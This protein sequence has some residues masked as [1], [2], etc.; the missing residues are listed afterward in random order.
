MTGSKYSYAATQL[1]SQG[2]LNP[3]AHMFLQDDF[4]QAEPDVV[5]AIMAA[6][7]EMKQLHLRKTFNPKH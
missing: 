6:H 5:E 7:S 2:V 4:Y 3:D 1:E